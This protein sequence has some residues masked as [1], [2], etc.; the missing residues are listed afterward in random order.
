[1]GATNRTQN[2]NLPQFVGS[3]KPTWLG[4]FNGAMS[5]IDTQMKENNDLGTNANTTAN[6]ALENAQTALETGTQA[7][8]KAN[9]AQQ[10][11]TQA[12]QK[13]LNNETKINNFNLD[14]VSN[15][16]I[17]H[18]GNGNVVAKTNETF[19]IAKN[20]TGSL[21]KIYGV[22]RLTNFGSENVT[23]TTNDTGLRPDTDIVIAPCGFRFFVYSSGQSINDVYLTIK[24]NGTIEIKVPYDAGFNYEDIYIFP[25]LIF[26]KD[27]GDIPSPDNN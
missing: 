8:E 2:Y 9:N 22:L 14:T 15:L 24:T 17:T 27:F 16:T 1:M 4:D 26:V 20:S 3:D 25:M 23:I 10:V 18:T 7:E 21:C 12:L 11:G 5:S 13:S 6:T 19:K